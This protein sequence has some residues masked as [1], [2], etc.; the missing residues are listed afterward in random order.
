MDDETVVVET[1]DETVVETPQEEV[2]YYDAKGREPR[3]SQKEAEENVR[4]YFDTAEVDEKGKKKG[5]DWYKQEHEHVAKAARAAGTDPETFAAI[6]SVASANN[7]WENT[8]PTAQR[9]VTSSKLH[10][11]KDVT[12]VDDMPDPGYM[13]AFVKQGWRIH[14]GEDPATVLG[15]KKRYNFYH[16][17]ADPEGTE[18]MVTVDRWIHRAILGGRNATNAEKSYFQVGGYDWAADVIRNVA[19]EVGYTPQELQAIVWVEIIRKTPKVIG[20]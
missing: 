14:R 6:T 9:I 2:V 1:P 12:F 11:D 5:Y 13:R 3:I 15:D 20:K 7:K 10:A 16:N 19:K 18:D 4:R 8:I 17:L